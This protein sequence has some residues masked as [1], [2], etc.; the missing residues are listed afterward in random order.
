MNWI[1]T[2]IVKDLTWLK[3]SFLQANR[4]KWNLKI[5]KIIY[6]GLPSPPRFI[7]QN[8]LCSVTLFIT[9]RIL[10]HKEFLNIILGGYAKFRKVTISLVM[11]VCPSAWKSALNAP[12]FMPDIR[13]FFWKSVKKIQV[14]L[15]SDTITGT[16]HEYLRTL[17]IISRWI[18]LR[19]RN[20]LDKFVEKIKRHILCSVIPSSP[21]P[22]NGAFYEIM[23][24]KSSIAGQATYDSIERRICFECWIIKA[25]RYTL[26]TCI[27]Y[28][29]STTTTVRRR[30][31]KRYYVRTFPLLQSN[32]S[33]WSLQSETHTW[34]NVKTLGPYLTIKT[35]F[36][37]RKYVTPYICQ[38]TYLTCY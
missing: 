9:K 30:R 34:K 11:S 14:G 5:W 4:R 6:T 35:G 28:C 36:Y 38:V 17:M 12:I 26:R 7:S 24:E 21:P 33:D 1:H 25:N 23:W 10:N 8:E 3:D 2:Q 13:G 15:Q 19:M 20:V 27:T 31:L 32:K 16:L 22:P 29:F 37:Q 18:L